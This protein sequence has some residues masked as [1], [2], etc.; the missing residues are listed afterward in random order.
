MASFARQRAAIETEAE[1]ESE[2]STAEAAIARRR[3]TADEATARAT[4]DRALAI[5][6]PP[7]L[8]GS[9]RDPAAGRGSARGQARPLVRPRR[10]EVFLT[11]VPGRAGWLG[12]AERGGSPGAG[13]LLTS[14]LI[15]EVDVTAG[16]Q[17]LGAKLLGPFADILAGATRVR[18]HLAGALE[19]LDWAQLP[20]A[21]TTLGLQLPIEHGLDLG[22]TAVAAAAPPRLLIVANPTRDLPG[23]EQEAAAVAGAFAGTREPRGDS[24]GT[25]DAGAAIGDGSAEILSGDRAGR[26]EVLAALTGVR[27]FHYA[28]HSNYLGPDGSASAL[29]LARGTHL[30]IGD[31]LSLRQ[32][33]QLVVLSGCEAA[34]DGKRATGVLGLAQAFLAAGV[35]A[36]VA[37]VGLLPDRAAVGPMG[38][39]Y[40]ELSLSAAFDGAAALWRARIALADG[41]TPPD[42]RVFVP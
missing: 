13:P 31:V 18:L 42:F 30:S 5:L 26:P 29:R 9:G 12:L 21:G 27:F 32:V 23:A 36:V 20:F 19:G 14:A 4:L 24:A 37:P 2:L 39:F 11:F 28:G 8:T 38:R 25:T 35:A 3:R 22:V 17:Q 15:G 16:R 33:P 7:A 41:P 1:R 6:A 34:G 40:R 10:G